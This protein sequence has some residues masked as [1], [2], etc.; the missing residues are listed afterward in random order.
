MNVTAPVLFEKRGL[1]HRAPWPRV[2][3]KEVAQIASAQRMKSVRDVHVVQVSSANST[4]G[5]SHTLVLGN[6]GEA[7]N[8]RG[9]FLLRLGLRFLTYEKR[10][11]GIST[12]TVPRYIKEE[13]SLKKNKVGNNGTPNVLFS[14]LRFSKMFSI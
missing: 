8:Q 5:Q 3:R 13:M 10:T 12:D 1:S 7:R 14:I 2:G 4:S 9:V 11:Y 6:N